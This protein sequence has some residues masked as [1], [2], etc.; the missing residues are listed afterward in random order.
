M[1]TSNKPITGQYLNTFMWELC[2]YGL[3]TSRNMKLKTKRAIYVT[4]CHVELFR[5]IFQKE[6]F[7]SFW[8]VT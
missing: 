7:T 1:K 5:I 4:D 8:K 3:I 2:C 6:P